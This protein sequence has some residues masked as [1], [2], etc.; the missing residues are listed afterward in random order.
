VSPRT[1]AKGVSG[2]KG[3]LVQ[4]FGRLVQNLILPVADVGMEISAHICVLMSETEGFF[5]NI[6]QETQ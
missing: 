3:H 4:T 6:E 1:S 2:K 5:P